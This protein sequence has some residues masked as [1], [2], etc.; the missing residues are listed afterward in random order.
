MFN[1]NNY[2]GIAPELRSLL[3]ANFNSL[4]PIRGK[5]FYVDPYATGERPDNSVADFQTAYGLCVSGRGDGILV[6]SGGTTASNTTSY[7]DTPLTWSKHAITVVGIAAPVSMFGRARIANVERTTGSLTTIAFP[8]A[9]TIT[10]SAEGFVT[11]GFEVGNIIRV[12]TAEGTNDGTGHIITAVTAGTIT[13]AASTFTVQTAATAG[14]TTVN[15]YCAELITVSGNN[16][17]FYNLHLGNYSSDALALGCVKVTG[18]RNYFGGCHFIGAGHATPGAVATAYDVE[19]NAGQE[20]TFEKCVFGTDSVL[21]AA[22]SGA[23]RFDTNAW[24]TRFYECE[25][26]KYS[27]TAGQGAI[28]VVDATGCDGVQLFKRCTFILWNENGIG[29]STAAVIGTKPNSGQLLFD[30]CTDLGWTAWGATGM[31]GCIYIANS[32]ATASGAG[33]IATTVA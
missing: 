31:S 5:W 1:I 2:Q 23:I 4:P 26:L 8:T 28:N 30:G 10:D 21:W 3:G 12:N 27:A 18:S 16:N 22:A 14:A 17:A 15:S 33:G 11:A 32:D 19:I 24:R 29:F 7:I 25:I 9:T 13:C 6:F 20:N